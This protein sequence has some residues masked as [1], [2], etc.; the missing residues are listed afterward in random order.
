MKLF[1][2]MLSGCATLLTFKVAA[3][4]IPM[5]SQYYM[6]PFIINPAFTG[7]SGEVNAF[8][9]HRSQFSG[10]AGAPQ[11]S[12]LT[13]DGPINVDGVGLGL[14][15]FSD[16][17]SI[18]SRTGVMGSYSYTLKINADNQLSFGLAAGILDHSINYNQAVV[19]DLDDPHLFEQRVHR[20][21][22]T[23]DA[24]LAYN[25]KKLQVGFSIPQFVSI[26]AKLR[27]D[28]GTTGFF[29]V[30]RQYQWTA[31]YLIDI[32][33]ERG[34]TAYPYVMVRSAFG[35]PVQYDLTGVLDWKKIGW[36]GVTYHS[37]FAVAASVGIRYRNLCVGYAHDFGV[38]KIRNY[39][40]STDEF[41]LSY[42]FGNDTKKRLD[43]HEKEIAELK[44]RTEQN[45]REIL[46]MK[47]DIEE[48]REEL[49]GIHTNEIHFRDSLLQVI[50]DMD[51]VKTDLKENRQP[52]PVSDPAK[53]PSRTS[54]AFRTAAAADFVDEYG[55]PLLKGYYVVI[56]SF[57][58][59]TNAVRFRDDLVANG[60]S[61]VMITFHK[62]IGIYNVYVLRSDDYSAAHAE[63]L[64]QLRKYANTWVLKLE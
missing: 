2:L 58:V 28:D 44:Q 27:S 18:L 38:T 35:T 48:I 60:E 39:T 22:F 25:W 21:V 49:E 64:K 54:G 20:T 9:M 1:I 45:E 37:D 57:G 41:L 16:V 5:G 3:Q 31:R 34:L 33:T 51:S 55:T 11:T 56:G 19:R 15:A 13:I 8:L 17:T 12:Y 14:N 23:A 63:R 7:T 29:D 43:Q 42:R 47:Q 50:Y 36:I 53:E 62:S 59:R 61:S 30:D 26:N 52:M 10:I 6:N 46:E 4:Q 40:G 32:N 24:G